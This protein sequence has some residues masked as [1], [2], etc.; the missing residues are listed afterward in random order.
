[1]GK[2]WAD[3]YRS[4]C[5][6]RVRLE[7]N[8]L[9]HTPFIF[10]VVQYVKPGDKVLEIGSGTGVMGWPL[11]QAGV[12][13]ISVDNDPGILEMAQIN[14]LVLGADIEYQEADAF[15]LPFSDREFRVA[16]SEGLIEHYSDDDIAKLVAEHQRV[17]DVV[18]ISVPLKGCG[19]IAFGNERWMTIEEWEDILKPMG[20][21]HG[22]L[23]GSEPN[24]CF[25]FIRVR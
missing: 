23:Y 24:A 8:I 4:I 20:A 13:V 6:N 15:H 9:E 5:G 7:G 12:K 16:F 17:A 19:N 3:F 11:V 18:V 22:L 21:V 10:E 2:T 25:T 14:S 1:M